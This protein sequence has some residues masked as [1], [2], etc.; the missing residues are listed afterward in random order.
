MTTKA[1]VLF[2][3]TANSARSQ[4]GEALLR[5]Y[6]GDTYEVFSAGLEAKGINPYTLRVLEEIGLDTSGQR[7][8]TISEYMGRMNFGVIITVCA[9]A[10]ARCPTTFLSQGAQRLRWP[11]DDPAAVE[12]DDA[13]K[14]AAFRR[15]RDEIDEK[16]RAWLRETGVPIQN[17]PPVQADL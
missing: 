16:I 11:F 6:A 2:L 8:K 3:C 4:L 14:L 17:A 12:G 13:A 5:R 10:D 7:S 1:K 9:N 15:I